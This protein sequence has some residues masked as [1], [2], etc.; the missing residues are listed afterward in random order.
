MASQQGEVSSLS[1]EHREYLLAR[2]GTLELDPVP[3]MNDAD[4]YN[5]AKSKKVINLLLVAF[6]A[7][8]SLFI[9]SSIQSSFES[10]AEDFNTSIQR[11]SYLVSIV[12]AVL[13]VAPIFWRP[14][15]ERFGRRPILIISLIFSAVGNI[16][17]AVS[18]SYATMGFCRAVTA[19]FIAPAAAIGS[20]VVSETFFK[21]ERAK[22]IGIWTLMLTLGVPVAPF[23]FGFV[24]MRVGYRWTFWILAIVS[25]ESRLN[26]LQ[27][28]LTMC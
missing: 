3:D 26:N 6:H 22:Y 14:L 4:P 17:C 12:I 11:V 16:G 13:G 10:I 21:H 1:K 27:S 8:M 2:H 25:R 19:F 23:I 9:A 28:K 24:T 18:P 5:W 15:S 20:A 7:M